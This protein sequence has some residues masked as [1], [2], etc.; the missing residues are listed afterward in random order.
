MS[1]LKQGMKL[2][3]GLKSKISC[4]GSKAL[5]LYSI[6]F[7]IYAP[8]IKSFSNSH[9]YN[10]VVTQLCFVKQRL[11][12]KSSKLP[13]GVPYKANVSHSSIE[14]MSW[15]ADFLHATFEKDFLDL[16]PYK[17]HST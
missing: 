12:G 1:I 14:A 16:V 6:L 10:N 9:Y 13:P 11:P 15:K 17:V 8:E 3:F 4:F 7:Y 2:L 5:T